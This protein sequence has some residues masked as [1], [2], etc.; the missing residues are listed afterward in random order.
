M[1]LYASN[2]FKDALANLG[3]QTESVLQAVQVG[4]ARERLTQ[5][6]ASG[7]KKAIRVAKIAYMDKLKAMGVSQ[8]QAAT[9]T[10]T[11]RRKIEKCC[12][13]AENAEEEAARIAAE[14]KERLLEE[15]E[16]DPHGPLREHI[17]GEHTPEPVAKN[18][19]APEQ[20]YIWY[21]RVLKFIG[22][23]PKDDK[24]CMLWHDFHDLPCAWLHAPVCASCR[25]Y[26]TSPPSC[27]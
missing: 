19:E 9:L 22:I 24:A 13:K 27:F 21:R 23:I 18:G 14:D 17:L 20:V 4:Q 7:D 16:S 8:P 15:A 6:E 1:L 5:A 25:L 12:N 2:D 26:S 10:E 11:I 3:S